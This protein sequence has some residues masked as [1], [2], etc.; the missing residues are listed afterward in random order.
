MLRILGKEPAT[1]KIHTLCKDKNCVNPTTSEL[2]ILRERKILI[3]R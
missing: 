3:K 1:Q 2:R